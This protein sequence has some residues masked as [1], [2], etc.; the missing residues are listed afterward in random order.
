VGFEG[1][2]FTVVVVF[3]GLLT[4]EMVGDGTIKVMVLE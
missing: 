1:R 2:P 3:E 4:N